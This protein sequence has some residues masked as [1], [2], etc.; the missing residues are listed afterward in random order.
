M[1]SVQPGE[2]GSRQISDALAVYLGNARPTFLELIAIPLGYLL[3]WIELL[4]YA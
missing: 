4:S 1:S 2:N 3:F